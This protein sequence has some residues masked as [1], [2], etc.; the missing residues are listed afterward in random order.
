M[1]HLRTSELPAIHEFEST[2][3][4]EVEHSLSTPELCF[5]GL[6]RTGSPVIDQAGCPAR[7]GLA[8]AS[9]F[10]TRT[11]PR[12]GPLWRDGDGLRF[13]ESPIL[14]NLGSNKVDGVEQA[15]HITHH[16]GMDLFDRDEHAFGQPEVGKEPVCQS[17]NHDFG[18][19]PKN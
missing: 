2:N 16:Q 1:R 9:P 7:L 14:D 18:R 4:L 19:A 6:K 8:A 13:T 12:P 17:S 15:R 3:A 5:Y 11:R 10:A